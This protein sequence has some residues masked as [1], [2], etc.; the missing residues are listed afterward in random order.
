MTQCDLTPAENA[1]RERRIQ[2]FRQRGADPDLA[3]QRA[4][5]LVQRDREGDTRAYCGE[6]WHLRG[7][8]CSVAGPPRRP[9]AA[10]GSEP[11]QTV[12]HR[13]APFVDALGMT[14]AR[15]KAA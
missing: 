11:D 5:R 14:V 12:L 6:C 8:V 9:H 10:R 1:L 4:D 3:E 7:A 2:L 13:C 15:R